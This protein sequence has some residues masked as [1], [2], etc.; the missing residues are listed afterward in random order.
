[1]ALAS[2]WDMKHG[3]SGQ[4]SETHRKEIT[5]IN[6]KKKPATRNRAKR[7]HGQIQ[8]T[9]NAEFPD[10]N[11]CASMETVNEELSL[12]TEL[13][14]GDKE[15]K[16]KLFYHLIAG[17][18]EGVS[19]I[20]LPGIMLATLEKLIKMC[21][22]YSDPRQ[23]EAVERYCFLFSGKNTEEEIETYVTQLRPLA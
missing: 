7:Q 6:R 14:M 10:T 22:Q 18:E 1:M 19:E 4:L 17:K 3:S 11:P 8:I 12:Y 20:L 9:G 16:L 21:D 23:N 15:N 13:A 5:M 2:K